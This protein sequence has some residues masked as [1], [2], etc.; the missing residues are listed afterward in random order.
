MSMTPKI[1]KMQL[2]MIVERATYYRLKISSLVRYLGFRT[3]TSMFDRFDDSSTMISSDVSTIFLK[4]YN[5]PNRN[6]NCSSIRDHL[7]EVEVGGSTQWLSWGN[8]W[9]LIDVIGEMRF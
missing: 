6:F 4:S 8:S 5:Y 3:G 2:K 1:P 9:I 7:S